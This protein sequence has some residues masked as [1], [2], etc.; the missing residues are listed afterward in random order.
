M[1]SQH[2][3]SGPVDLLQLAAVDVKLVPG[4]SATKTPSAGEEA[5][6]SGADATAT[7]ETSAEDVANDELDRE[8][9]GSDLD[10]E[11]QT[12]H[13]A[14]LLA[15]VGAGIAAVV[16]IV[17][18]LRGGTGADP[19][20]PA[21]STIA[22][23]SALSI[24][25]KLESLPPPPLASLPAE[26]SPRPTPERRPVSDPPSTRKASVRPTRSPQTVTRRPSTQAATR[27]PAPAVTKVK[28]GPTQLP[29]PPEV[30][31]PLGPTEAPPVPSSS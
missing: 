20:V 16:V 4:E 14:R 19:Q 7:P 22:P 17:L 11:K 5:S 10:D 6:A 15:A 18:L 29:P 23:S 26:A 3:R 28:S 25:E 27:S 13:R 8:F 31:V 12:G 24:P 1:P 30:D 9:W 2:D 21:P